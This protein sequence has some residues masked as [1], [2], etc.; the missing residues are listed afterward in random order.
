VITGDFNG[1]G[2]VDLATA[3]TDREHNNGMAMV[4]LGNG[5][6]TFQA[7][8][9][10]PT[11]GYAGYIATAD[12]NGDGKA[13]LVVCNNATGLAGY[14]SV[15]LGNGDG[16]FQT[17][18]NYGAGNG[19]WSVGVADFDGDGR[20]DL[21]VADYAGLGV[22]VFL[23]SGAGTFL[24]AVRYSA[25]ALPEYVAVADFNG[26]GKPDF[27]V[28]DYLSNNLSVFL[29]KGDGT[30]QGPAFF[31]VPLPFGIAVED[32]NGDG[33]ADLVV[34]YNANLMQQGHVNVLLGN[35]GGGFATPVSYATGIAPYALAIADFNGDGRA[36]IV[37]ANTGSNTGSNTGNP[38]TVSI[39]LALPPVSDL[40]IAKTH[41]GNFVQGQSL[42]TYAITVSNAGRGPTS[43]TVTVTDVLPGGLT[44]TGVP[45]EGGLTG[46]DGAGWTCGVAIL[47]CTRND[48][49]GPGAAYPPITVTL[50][51]AFNAASSVTNTAAVSGGGETNTA[52]DSATDPTVIA[53][54][55]PV[56]TI[57]FA[58][59]PNVAV[60]IPPFKLSGTASSGL[61]VSFA[62]N[63]LKVCTI[64]GSSVTIVGSGGCSITASQGG[65]ASYSAAAPV[66]QKFTVFF[67]D[68]TPDAYYYD[69]VNLFAQY[70]IT[71]GC[72]D[73]D[74][75]PE[76]D[77]TR[78][79]MAVF[80]VRAVYGGDNFTSSPTPYFTDVEPSTFGFKWIQKLYE[81][82]IT[83][84][85][86]ATTYCPT[87]TVTRDHLALFVIRLRYGLSL[88]GVMP[89]RFSY[90]AIPFFTDVPPTDT[91]FASVQR[92]KQD[93]ITNGCAPGS[94][95]PGAPVIRGDMAIFVLRAALNQLLPAGTPVI[96]QITPSTL[97]VGTSGTFTIT[98]ANTN[99]AQGT[100]TLSPIPGVAIGTIT[101]NSATSL[102]VQLAAAANAAPQPY[103]VV[104]I[105]GTEFDALPSGLVIQ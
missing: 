20:A 67:N 22:S 103:S 80:L 21:V 23:N 73:N 19:P 75:C 96:R 12:F 35:G 18:V 65:N 31:P 16:T 97:A 32:F 10:Y 64:S 59:L 40:V 43:G 34:G 7:A 92:M 61:A 47:T 72:G 25:G 39:L 29:G 17:P 9:A 87:D 33:N 38:G 6:G 85:C 26:D 28:T 50:N 42:A 58:A 14:I 100:T 45:Q 24:P 82:G 30:F 102:T 3:S 46:V 48:T 101:V 63:A 70:G 60:T 56:Q 90:T 41:S 5:D 57:S 51:V 68:V 74:Y 88:A 54:S 86:T 36:D 1:D 15:L 105:T 8:V 52:N 37:T 71:A 49:L 76:M 79:Q 83:K 93:G 104:A 77:V 84:G 44:S 94:Y 91:A 13:D 98:G 11:G 78:D 95:C 2:K 66:T 55:L 99:F 89:P 4:L 62:S 69:A 81:L 53:P 27:A